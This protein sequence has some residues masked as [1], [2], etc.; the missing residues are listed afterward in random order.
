[1]VTKGMEIFQVKIHS[2]IE[3]VQEKSFNGN[4]WNELK[5][6]RLSIRAR[7]SFGIFEYLG[8][9]KVSEDQRPSN[10]AYSNTEKPKI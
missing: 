9:F 8:S 3:A 4:L 10:A 5:L 2:H 6:E 1:M 7:R